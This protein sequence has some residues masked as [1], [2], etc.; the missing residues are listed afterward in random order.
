MQDSH[1]SVV[2][3]VIVQIFPSLQEGI[4]GFFHK[5]LRYIVQRT[6]L[7]YQFLL[8]SQHGIWT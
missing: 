8:I 2:Q 3:A 4:F 1:N 6:W 7:F 5:Q